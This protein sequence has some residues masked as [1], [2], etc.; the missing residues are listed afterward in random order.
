MAH[1]SGVSGEETADI[2]VYPTLLRNKTFLEYRK[3]IWDGHAVGG[4]F[5][6]LLCW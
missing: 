3:G 6:R 2:S 5:K 1:F 4:K